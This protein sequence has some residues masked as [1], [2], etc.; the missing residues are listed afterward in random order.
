MELKGARMRF[1]VVFLLFLSFSWPAHAKV[2]QGD[3]ESSGDLRAAPPIEM[4]PFR[5]SCQVELTDGHLRSRNGRPDQQRLF[6]VA[7]FELSKEKPRVESKDLRWSW[8]WLVNASEIEGG[9][10]IEVL[11]ERAP[12]GAFSVVHHSF[13]MRVGKGQEGAFQGVLDGWFSI[14]VGGFLVS[15]FR[16]VPFLQSDDSVVLRANIFNVL[17]LPGK[18]LSEPR[19]EAY[20]FCEK[21]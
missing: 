6:A 15:E 10:S 3:W 9:E 7:K 8:L 20:V 16:S 11:L 2:L 1:F 12:K 21:R 17:N 18:R 14:P 19:L 4:L 13:S 5:Y